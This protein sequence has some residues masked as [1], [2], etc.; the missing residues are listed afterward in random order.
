MH[1]VLQ[2]EIHF[3]L[4]LYPSHNLPLQHQG[5]RAHCPQS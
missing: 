2:P 3:G 4:K 1:F 5:T